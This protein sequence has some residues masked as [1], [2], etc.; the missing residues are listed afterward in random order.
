MIILSPILTRF[1]DPAANTGTENKITKT[2]SKPQ[3]QKFRLGMRFPP[4]FVI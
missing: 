2:S 4:S 1:F 3:I